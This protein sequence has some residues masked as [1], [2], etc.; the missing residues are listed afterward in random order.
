MSSPEVEEEKTVVE[1]EGISQHVET[2]NFIDEE[3]LKGVQGD[4]DICVVAL[5]GQD[6]NFTKEGKLDANQ[7]VYNWDLTLLEKRKVLR[8]VDWHIMPLAAWSCGLQFVDKV[9]HFVIA[10][11]MFSKPYV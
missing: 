4:I 9:R 5:Q 1:P 6:L 2:Y 8:K 3:E 7:H 11:Q 10:Q